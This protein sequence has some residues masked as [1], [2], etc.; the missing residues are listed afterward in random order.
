MSSVDIAVRVLKSQTPSATQALLTVESGLTRFEYVPLDIMATALKMSSAR[1]RHLLDLLVEDEL[2][3]A[4]SAPYR[5]YT[6]T[7]AGADL[8]AL[9]ALVEKNVLSAVGKPLGVGKESEVYDALL[10]VDEEVVAVKFHRIGRISFRQTRRLRAYAVGARVGW[11]VQAN[12]AAAREFEALTMLHGAHVSVPKPIYRTRHVV[13]MSA[14]DGRPLIEYT[15]AISRELVEELFL[16]IRGMYRAGVVHADMSEFNVI[17]SE[18]GH[19]TLFDFPQWVQPS[20]KSADKFLSSDITNLLIFL[21]KRNVP[22]PTFP[23]ILAYVK[24]G[25]EG[26]EWA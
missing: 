24:G 7:Y 2:L 3:R 5:G 18:E 17:V 11:I 15:H 14:L 9:K 20:H 23:S 26:M 21:A 19:I 8:L 13:V 6:L 10:D 25:R 1:T 12:R 16:N 4:V 22:H